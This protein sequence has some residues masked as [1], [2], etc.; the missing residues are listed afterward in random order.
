MPSRS[1]Q[2][3]ADPPEGFYPYPR[4]SAFLDLV[5]PLYQ[6]GEGESLQVGMWIDERHA[7]RNGGCHGGLLSTIADSFL[8]RFA[9]VVRFGEQAMA[10]DHPPAVVTMHL[11]V[12]FLGPVRRGAWIQMGARAD[13]IG[14]KTIYTSGLMTCD[15]APVL[16]ANGI[17]QAKPVR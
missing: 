12:D 11:S 3:P 2:V 14:H 13:R 9:S 5:G 15:G 16:R 1:R 4:S 6:C 7:N 17:F 10:G 8:T